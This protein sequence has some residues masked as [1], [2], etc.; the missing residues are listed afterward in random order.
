MKTV[1]DL[2]V[3]LHF[4]NFSKDDDDDNDCE[5]LSVVT[6]CDRLCLSVVLNILYKRH[7]VMQS[8]GFFSEVCLYNYIVCVK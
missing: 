2:C 8:Y 3:K 5:I 4:A 6:K 1:I 7:L